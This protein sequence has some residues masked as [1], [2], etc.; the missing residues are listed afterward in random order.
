MR[1]AQDEDGNYAGAYKSFLAIDNRITNGYIY[2]MGYWVKPENVEEKT[3][4]FQK[5]VQNC[6]NGVYD[7][8]GTTMCPIATPETLAQMGV[9]TTEA[10]EPYETNEVEGMLWLCLKHED[11]ETKQP[12]AKYG[13]EPGTISGRGMEN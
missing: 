12:G 2:D 1:I 4:E 11:G 9:T 10:E 13:T 3:P 5:W 7:Y 8:D 6:Y